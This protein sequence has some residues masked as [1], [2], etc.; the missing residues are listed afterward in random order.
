MTPLILRTASFLA[1][2]AALAACGGSKMT[3]LKVTPEQR[4]ANS[5]SVCLLGPWVRRAD[6]SLTVAEME[7]GIDASFAAA[8]LNSDGK[9][10]YDEIGRV[11]QMR[12]GSC[13]SSS[14]VS[15][16]GTGVIRR[17]E[18]GARYQTA[19]LS[20]DRDGDGFATALDLANPISDTV[21]A[22][23]SRKRSPQNAPPPPSPNGDGTATGIP[24]RSSSPIPTSTAP[25]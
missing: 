23:A 16:D 22:I 12:Q 14:L 8:D 9:L 2:A 10:T 24:D 19:F 11:N 1:I 17:E 6:G 13:D 7:A 4:A 20:A 3:Q 21:R 15:W 18:Y 25:Y 5:P